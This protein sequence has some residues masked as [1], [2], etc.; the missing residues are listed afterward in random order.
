MLA[1]PLITLLGFPCPTCMKDA[2][3]VQ[4]STLLHCPLVQVRTFASIYVC[5]SYTNTPPDYTMYG[6]QSNNLSAENH[7]ELRRICWD[8]GAISAGNRSVTFVSQQIY[9]INCYRTDWRPLSPPAT[10][11]AQRISF[12]QHLQKPVISIERNS[13]EEGAVRRSVSFSELERP[14]PTR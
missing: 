5:K 13:S 7:D 14:E 4:L 11:L 10:C 9:I 6:D 8:A 12:R 3:N 2:T 1:C